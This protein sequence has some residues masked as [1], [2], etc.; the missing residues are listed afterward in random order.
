MK[1]HNTVHILNGDSLKERFPESLVGEIVVAREC[2]VNGNISGSNLNEFFR[3]RAAFLIGEGENEWEEY[4]NK[5]ASEFQRI[6]ELSAD[7]EVNMWFEDDLFC[8][9]NFWF[10]INLIVKH[11]EVKA[12]YLVRPEQ[13]NRYGFSGHDKEDLDRLFE[14][15]MKLTDVDR[16]AELW[17]HYQ[18]GDINSLQQLARNFE[19]KYPFIAEAV[20]AHVERLPAGEDPGRVIRALKEIKKDLKTDEFDPIFREFCAR[21]GIY[22]FGDQHVKRL[23]AEISEEN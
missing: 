17:M 10:T 22:G 9:V 12:I 6:M 3:N 1:T 8:Q 15:R 19:T 14:N 4:L 20:Q 2:L 21:E 18:S 23:L 13:Q 11:T 16:L 5:S 7:A